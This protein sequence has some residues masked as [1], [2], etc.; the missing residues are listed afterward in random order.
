M[1]HI[2]TEVRNENFAELK[3]AV[4]MLLSYDRD[5]THSLRQVHGP[6]PYECSQCVFLDAKDASRVANRGRRA[7]RFA[8]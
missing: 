6:F 4:R 5:F 7:A 3:S 8:H 1:W 2:Y